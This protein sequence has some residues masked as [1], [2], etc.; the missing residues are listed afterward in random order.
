MKSEISVSRVS[1]TLILLGTTL[2]LSTN[3]IV[4][5]W[6]DYSLSQSS[7]GSEARRSIDIMVSSSLTANDAE[8]EFQ[9]PGDTLSARLRREHGWSEEFTDAALEGYRQ[10]MKLKIL[11]EDWDADKLSPSL[12]IDRVWHSHILDTK[13]YARASDAYYLRRSHDSPQSRRWIEPRR[14]LGTHQNYSGY[15]NWTLWKQV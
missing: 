3:D 12:I 1:S 8:E 2:S 14:T 15:L 10:F 6:R 11:Q 13:S 4:S 5:F 9:I 7:S